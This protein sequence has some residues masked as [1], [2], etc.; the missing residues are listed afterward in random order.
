MRRGLRRTC[1]T[2]SRRSC[3]RWGR[4]TQQP[5]R[6]ATPLELLPEALSWIQRWGI[7]RQAFEMEAERGAVREKLPDRV[8]A[9]N[10][11]PI[12]DEHHAARD[13]APPVLEKRH[14]VSRM[15]RTVLAVDVE[16][17]RGRNGADGG[18]M[19]A[20]VPLPQDGRL[21]HRRIATHDP[22]QGREPRLISEEERLLLGIGPLLSAGQVSL[23]QR[24]MATSS[25][26]C[27]R[28]IGC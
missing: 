3:R 9:G 6:N 19:I 10:R 12:P 18:A 26:C 24:A 17:T 22:G 20:S 1:V 13:L 15:D 7:A 16:R 28:R 27:A 11:Y 5:W 8:A 25:R 4:S 2:A 23:R 14:H 21:P